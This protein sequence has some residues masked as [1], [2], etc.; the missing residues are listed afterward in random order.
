MSRFIE[1]ITITGRIIHTRFNN[2]QRTVT[3]KTD[4]SIYRSDRQS[5]EEF[6]SMQ[7]MTGN[8]WNNWLKFSNNYYQVK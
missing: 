3:I 7:H 6:Q 5:F 1:H 8:D 4:T 2:S